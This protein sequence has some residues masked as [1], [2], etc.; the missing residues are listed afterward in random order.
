MKNKIKSLIYGSAFLLSIFS[1]VLFMAV[2]SVE[3]KA[4]SSLIG[5]GSFFVL[6]I[7]GW[8]DFCK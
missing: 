3:V 5:A 4:V 1:F 2:P 8:H 6:S 7:I